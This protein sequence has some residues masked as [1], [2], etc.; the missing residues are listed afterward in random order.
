[1]ST[2]PKGYAIEL[3]VNAEKAEIGD[4]GEIQFIPDPGKLTKCE[5][6]EDPN[7]NLITTIDRNQVISPYY[8]SMVLQIICTGKDRED[9]VKK[10]LTYLDNVVIRGVC[11]NIPLLKKILNDKEFREN[12]YDTGYL[13]DFLNRID[14]KALIKEIEKE[15]GGSRGQINLDA[16]KIEDSNELKV[17]APS[18][19]IFYCTPSP[20]EPDFVH[21]NDVISTG[22][23]IC[24]L[25]AMKLFRPINLNLF[26]NQSDDVYDSNRKYRV[27]RIN[28]A[29][30][31]AVNQ[32]DLLFVIEPI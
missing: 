8:D 25:E 20:S 17:L 12:K 10:L 21:V 11:T 26:N 23:T 13:P 30:G 28:P 31:Q 22:D 29:N 5:L 9:T 18:A 7:I 32:G 2:L 3:R 14:T 19:G 15:A 24:L 16:L 6:P 1:M 27:V 4:D